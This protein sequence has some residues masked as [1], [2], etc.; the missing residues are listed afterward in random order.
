MTGVDWKKIVLANF[1]YD[2]TSVMPHFRMCSSIIAKNKDGNILHGRNLD[3]W[4]GT[5]FSRDSAII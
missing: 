3:L 1:I 2:L 5:L 4:P